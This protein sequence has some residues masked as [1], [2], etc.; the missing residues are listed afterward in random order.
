VLQLDLAI[1]EGRLRFFTNESMVPNA[2]ELIERLQTV[3][4]ERQSAL[5]EA[6]R[7]RAQV[8]ARIARTILDVCRM[9]GLDLDEAQQARILSERDVDVLERWSDRAFSV[10]AELFSS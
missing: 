3:T 10:T 8:I 2:E 1:V 7:A 9:R 5:E 6:E 4:D